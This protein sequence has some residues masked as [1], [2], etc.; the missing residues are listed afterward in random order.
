MNKS[1]SYIIPIFNEEENIENTIKRIESSFKK[2]DLTKYEIIFVDDGSTDNTIKII[3][4]FISEGFPLKCI[5]I[6][7][8]R[9]WYIFFRS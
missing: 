1:I 7:L 8:S 4:K 2:N 9:F 5:S 6:K 3:K